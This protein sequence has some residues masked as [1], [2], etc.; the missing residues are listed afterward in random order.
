MTFTFE[1]AYAESNV[2]WS[3]FYT[4]LTPEH[5]MRYLTKKWGDGAEYGSLVKLS[6][7]NEGLKLLRV[8]NE[9]LGNAKV[10]G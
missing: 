5:S 1:K 6:V 7:K 10:S 2:D 8:K 9:C 3:G 4:Q